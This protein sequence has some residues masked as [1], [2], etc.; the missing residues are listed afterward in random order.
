[1]KGV[2]RIVAEDFAP[3]NVDVT[4]QD[5][6]TEALRH[7]GRGDAEY[8][9]R[10]VIT[11]TDVWPGG[12][13][14]NSGGVAYVAS[15][16]SKQTPAFVFSSNLSSFKTVGDA[17]STATVLAGTSESSCASTRRRPCRTCSR[18]SPSATREVRSSRP[19]PRPR[20]W[21]PG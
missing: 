15:F 13:F 5:P 7:S 6:G 4:T 10:I 11:P 17:A 19:T 3:F 9:T 1:V 20:W 18:R 12:N 2:W 8:G 14:S 16:K 21:R